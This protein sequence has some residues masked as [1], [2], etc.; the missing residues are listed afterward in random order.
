MALGKDHS[1]QGEAA[2]EGSVALTGSTKVE[3]TEKNLV[4]Q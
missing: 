4:K 2:L 3:D 1:E